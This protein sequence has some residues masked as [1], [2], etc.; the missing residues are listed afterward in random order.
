M[1][2]AVLSALL[3]VM[4][5]ARAGSYGSPAYSGGTVTTVT[6]GGTSA[7]T[8]DSAFNF[9]SPGAHGYK[10]MDCHGQITA[11][12]PWAASYAGEPVPQSVIV[13]KTASASCDGITYSYSSYGSPTAACADGL[14]DQ[15]AIN[16]TY[17]PFNDKMEKSGSAGATKYE[18][19]SG[20]SSLAV[21]CTPTASASSPNGTGYARV[22]FTAAVSPVTIQIT[23]TTVDSNGNDN[24]LIGQHCGASLAGIPGSCTVSN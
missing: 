3:S 13:T 19:T 22:S 8:A 11:T 1:S 5:A 15:G 20:A 18:A 23:G 12:F 7:D 4:P 6:T 16:S 10:S 17:I 24:I 2:C 21:T 14:G 9:D